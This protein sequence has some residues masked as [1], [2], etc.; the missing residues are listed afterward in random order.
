MTFFFLCLFF[1][2]KAAVPEAAVLPPANREEAEKF[3]G[4]A[5]GKY[6]TR[7]YYGALDDLDKALKLNTFL[8]DYYFMRGL[9][10]HR[11]GRTDDALKS[12][13]YFLEV[14]PGD[15]AV[16]R[17]LSR[18]EEEGRF[19]GDV[20]AGR[21]VVSRTASSMRDLRTALA[22]PV[23]QSLGIKGLGKVK[24]SP[25]GGL[26]VA[27]TLGA[28]LWIRKPGE[29]SFSGIDMESPVAVLF[30]GE[31]SGVVLLESGKVLSIGDGG[32]EPTELGELP[33][34][35]SD[36]A[37]ISENTF[38]A[39]SAFKRKAG[40]F[41]LPD[42]SLVSELTFP[43][44]EHPFEPAAA[45][46][47]GEWLAVAD[48]NNG[49]VFLMSLLER[50]ALFS[51]KAD[52]PRDLA[53]S[54]LGDLFVVHEK[55]EVS[56]TTLSFETMEAVR[57]ETVIREAPGAWSLFSLEDRVYCLDVAGFS[58]WEMYVYPE[59]SSPA[60]LSLDTP[61]VRREEDRESFLLEASVSGPY[62][63]YMSKNRPVVTS[64]WNERMLT[65]GFRFFGGQ[66][67]GPAVF[68]LPPGRRTA[69]QYHEAASGKEVLQI[70][71]KLWKEKKNRLT[72]VVAAS[73]IPFSQEEMKQL[74]GFCLQNGIRLFVFC[75]S[76]SP[77]P[78]LRASALTGGTPLFSLGGELPGSSSSR[79]GE[80]RIPLP[81]DETSSGFPS[82]SVLSVYMD[83][84]SASSR[85]WMPLWP[86][87][88]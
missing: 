84:G 15:T 81:S 74:A 65:A 19:L 30:S 79:R 36:G 34:S 67:A 54:A 73:S 60:F 10:L 5:Y 69:D 40:I 46:V 8:V 9:V 61:S 23:F 75:D 17:I 68:F 44:T 18:F 66:T 85:D 35:P 71:G 22:L 39:V 33:F 14:R 7:D 55:G 12:L 53:W 27:D 57:S 37:M 77:I 59:E 45:A 78:L 72:D 38:V 43:E 86:D 70:L 21:P 50:R 24:S 16:P 58:L 28:R 47:Y 11:I 25:S 82:R 2:F 64:V 4:S 63:T 42:V 83:I 76:L 56:K 3:F 6:C 31:N 26:A 49:A 52:S 87:L 32:E 48:R 88:L 20:L 62:S 80:V 29:R 1:F 41:S 51:F 13:K